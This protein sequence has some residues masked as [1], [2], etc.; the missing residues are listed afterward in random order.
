M[1]V[2]V[3]DERQARRNLRVRRDVLNEYSYSEL[4]KRYRRDC[5]GISPF[6]VID[7]RGG[8]AWPPL[9]K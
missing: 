2:L 8:I 3:G 6:W 1:A 9:K 7:D 4:L 5:E